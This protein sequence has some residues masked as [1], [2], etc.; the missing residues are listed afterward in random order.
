MAQTSISI[1]PEAAAL[2]TEELLDGRTKQTLVTR[3]LKW[4][5]SL[6]PDARAAIVSGMTVELKVHALE[7]VT[8]AMR[9]NPAAFGG[10]SPARPAVEFRNHDQ[11]DDPP[12]SG[13]AEDPPPHRRKSP[14]K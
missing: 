2:L 11:P 14:R 9:R 13:D 1:E 3:L 5:A 6:P 12:T 8:Q 4:Y 7:S 10:S